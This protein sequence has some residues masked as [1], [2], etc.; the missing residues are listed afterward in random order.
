[1]L[2][3]PELWCRIRVADMAWPTGGSRASPHIALATKPQIAKCSLVERGRFLLHS[4]V[5]LPLSSDAIRV[6]GDQTSHLVLQEP[7]MTTLLFP[8]G[9]RPVSPRHAVPAR[10]APAP[11]PLLWVSTFLAAATVAL[12]ATRLLSHEAVA[13][14]AR[15]VQPDPFYQQKL[16]AKADE[17]PAQ[18]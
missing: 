3:L 11:H 8:A 13:L 2:F 12:V 4:Q 15:Q 9:A 16:D 5:R 17:L 18:F 7:P 14:E 6:R 10:P 1:M